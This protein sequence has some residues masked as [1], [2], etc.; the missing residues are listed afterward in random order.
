MT[1]YCGAAL[2]LIDYGEHTALYECESGH[3]FV[4]NRAA[5]PLRWDGS[6]NPPPSVELL[7]AGDGR[8]VE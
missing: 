6:R 1:C 7:V 5:L 8:S 3:T 2:R 4:W